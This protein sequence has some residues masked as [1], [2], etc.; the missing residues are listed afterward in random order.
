MLFFFY[1]WETLSLNQQK[2]PEVKAEGV[3]SR[4]PI[5]EPWLSHG[6]LFFG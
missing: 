1:C 5:L 4:L 3:Q 2:V 6:V